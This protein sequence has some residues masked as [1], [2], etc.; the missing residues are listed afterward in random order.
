MIGLDNRD[1]QLVLQRHAQRM[2][3]KRRL[4]MNELP[5]GTITI[6]ANHHAFKPAL[7]GRINTDLQFDMLWQSPEW[8]KPLPWLGL[9]D[10]EFAAKELIMEALAGS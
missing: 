5:G 1:M 3:G 2:G 8:I 10:V 4:Y 9:E 6:H 7:I